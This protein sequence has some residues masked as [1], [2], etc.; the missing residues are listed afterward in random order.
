[1]RVHIVSIYRWERGERS[2]SGV[3]MTALERVLIKAGLN[4]ADFGIS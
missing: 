1:M 4:P 2:I 3:V